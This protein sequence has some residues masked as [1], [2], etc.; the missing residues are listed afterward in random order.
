MQEILLDFMKNVFIHSPSLS[1]FGKFK[2]SIL[3]LAIQTAKESLNDFQNQYPNTS[4]DFLIFTSF[5]PEVYTKEFHLPTRIQESLGLKD[6]FCFRTE[7]ASSSGCSAFHLGVRLIQSGKFETGLIIASEIMSNLSREENNIL[8]ASVL[9]EKQRKLGMS[10]A[11]GGALVATRYLYEYGYNKND[12]WFLSK[13]LHDNGLKN[14]IAHIQKNLNYE[15]YLNAPMFCSPLGLYDIS[16][17][18][19]GCASLILSN[20]ESRV[21]VLGLGHGTAPMD[22]SIHNLSFPASIHAYKEAYKESNLEPK[23]I[24]VAELHDAFTIFE[25]IGAE[26]GGLLPKG[27]GLL[28]VREGK[29][30][31]EGDLPINPSGGLKSRGH[32]IGASGLAQICEFFRFWKIRPDCRIGLTHS[33]GGLATNNFVTILE[34]QN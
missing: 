23:D 9:S 30:H 8:L 4:I 25:I 33:I 16:P 1:K 28:Y 12:L 31:I 27:K 14:P 29:T 18:S 32:P 34:Y 3:E 10:M 21:R 26:D 20:K 11:Q 22:H 24:Q 7:T 19:D 2:G 15:D 13:K 6:A 5:C 17:L